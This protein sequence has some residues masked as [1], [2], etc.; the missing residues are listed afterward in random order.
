VRLLQVIAVFVL[1]FVL[2]VICFFWFRFVAPDMA[3]YRFHHSSEVYYSTLTKSC[4]TIITEHPLGTN[5]CI[6]LSIS[7]PSLPKII[8]DLQPLKIQ[9]W[10]HRIW[11][12]HGGSAEFGIEWQQDEIHTNVW[13]LNT[14]RESQ[15]E[16][17]YTA[18]K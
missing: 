17:A 4:D 14:A 10:P 9:V 13:T 12:L 8:H 5:R 6:E 18:S 15:I 11:I 16:I 7:D 3:F 2:L 1:L